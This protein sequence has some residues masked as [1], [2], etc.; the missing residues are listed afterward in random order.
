M[1]SEINSCK[2]KLNVADPKIR[3]TAIRAVAA[4]AD[5][6]LLK[7]ML[8]TVFRNRKGNSVSVA[9]IAIADACN[10]EAIPFLIDSYQVASRNERMLIAEA[11]LKLDAFDHIFSGNASHKNNFDQVWALVF[12]ASSQQLRYYL[13]LPADELRKELDFA[14]ENNI[15]LAERGMML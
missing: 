12:G 1:K 5:K 13:E 10:K 4:S 7:Y 8:D 15:A 11:L 3:N 2:S 9:V 6:T 14:L